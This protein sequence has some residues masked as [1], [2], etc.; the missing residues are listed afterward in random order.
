MRIT[1]MQFIPGA[2]GP[3]LRALSV[4]AFACLCMLGGGCKDK[5]PGDGQDHLLTLTLDWQP[6]PEFGG[7]YA[8]QRDGAFS[9]HAWT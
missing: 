8:A 6:E 9:K 7:F 5:S 1:S 3:V 4:V 2:A